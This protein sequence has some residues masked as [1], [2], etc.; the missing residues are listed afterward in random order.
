MPGNEVDEVTR[1]WPQVMA[2]LLQMW[3]RIQRASADGSVR[4][5]RTE[6]KQFVSEFRDAQK[7]LTHQ[8]ETTRAWYQA[9][10]EDY[11]RESRAAKARANAGASAEEQAGVAA[12][13]RG[14]R[15]GIEHTIHDTVL[16]AEQRGQVVQTLDAIDADRETPVPRNIFR[17]I[18]GKA[19]VQARLA[20]A[21][22]E[23]RVAEHREQRAAAAEEASKPATADTSEMQRESDKRFDELSKRI[24]Q[25]EERLAVLIPRETATAATTNGHAKPRAIQNA[26]QLN[27]QAQQPTQAQ[28][29][30]GSTA[31]AGPAEAQAETP[32]PGHQ[33]KA[34]AEAAAEF[35]AEMEAEA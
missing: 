10:V 9:R 29:A 5:S 7:L 32:N 3:Q 31:T 1:N 17:P 33:P 15:A 2:L 11:Q 22:S 34:N 28:P 23:N 4:L 27:E 26:S 20:A 30:N 13:L 19:A 8:I 14:L 25:L 24:E 16:T 35:I 18:T 21:E 6:Y 12:Y